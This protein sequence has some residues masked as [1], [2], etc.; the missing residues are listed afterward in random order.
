M[1]PTKNH[2]KTNGFVHKL[3]LQHACTCYYGL[4]YIYSIEKEPAAS[5]SSVLSPDYE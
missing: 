5:P 3:I 4:M 2:S 1:Y